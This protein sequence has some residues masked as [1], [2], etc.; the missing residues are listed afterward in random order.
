MTTHA[1]PGEQEPACRSEHDPIERMMDEI[2]GHVG[3]Y[4]PFFEPVFREAHSG[5]ALLT[6]NTVKAVLDGG[7]PEASFQATLNACA[8]R[9]PT[10]VIY[11]EAAIA[12]K[13]DV[14]K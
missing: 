5:R 7:F 2:A 12:Y 11:L 8:K 3:F 1:D 14:K 9:L 13:K 4:G 10:P 6:F